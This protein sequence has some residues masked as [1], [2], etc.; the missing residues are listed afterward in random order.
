MQTE[1][2]PFEIVIHIDEAGTRATA[3]YRIRILD[4]AGAVIDGATKMESVTM[5]ELGDAFPWKEFIDAATQAMLV[6]V[7][8]L[9]ARVASAESATAAETT[10]KKV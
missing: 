9:T 2:K 6:Q 1:K 5:T 3:S 8:M 7:E 4:D 10:L